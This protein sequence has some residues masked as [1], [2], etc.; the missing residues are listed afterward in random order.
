MLAQRRRANG[1]ARL[2]PE[3]GR[4]RRLEH[5]AGG[6]EEQRLVEAAFTCQPPAQHVGRVGQRL[7]AVEHSRGGV[8][9][10]AEP[11]RAGRGR[12]RLGE[13]QPVP[14]PG[15]HDA[16]AAVEVACLLRQQRRDLL[17]VARPKHV[18]QPQVLA[19]ALE[20]RSR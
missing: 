11:Y 8:L 9:D 5:T 18:G 17:L 2:H 15:D 14:T 19:R 4:G 1:A 12:Q 7:D 13:E 20:S 6:D 3:E 16:Q 10:H